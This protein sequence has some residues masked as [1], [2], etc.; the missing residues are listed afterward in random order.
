MPGKGGGGGAAGG[1]D[2]SAKDLA[3]TTLF[4][5]LNGHD[6]DRTTLLGVLPIG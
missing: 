3:R 2:I 6:P 1:P 5:R 4:G